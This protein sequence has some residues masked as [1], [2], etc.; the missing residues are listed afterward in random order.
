MT[1][2]QKEFPASETKEGGAKKPYVTPELIVHGAVEKLT[3]NTGRG[4]QQDG[5]GTYRSA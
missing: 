2:D 1:V 4:T 3:E 5:L